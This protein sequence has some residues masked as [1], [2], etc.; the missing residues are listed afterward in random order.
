LHDVIDLFRRA[1]ELE[2]DSPAGIVNLCSIVV[3]GVLVAGNTVY[4][5]MELGIYVM[6]RVAQHRQAIR[7]G[8]PFK[9]QPPKTNSRFNYF[10]VFAV[11]A[12]ACPVSIAAI[13]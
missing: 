12:L 9:A 1:I 13:P 7:L 5:F 4:R 2:K 11:I 3:L 6:E 8:K 10:V